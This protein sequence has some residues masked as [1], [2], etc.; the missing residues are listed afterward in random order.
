MVTT[1]LTLPA[2]AQFLH[3]KTLHHKPSTLKPFS[4]HS[5]APYVVVRGSSR[6]VLRIIYG[7]WVFDVSN[8]WC[9]SFYCFKFMVYSGFQLGV[10]TNT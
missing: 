5:A 3:L 1:P 4:A 9:M 6:A 7:I 10:R 2:K 8:V